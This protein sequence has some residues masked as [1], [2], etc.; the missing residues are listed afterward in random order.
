M[1]LAGSYGGAALAEDGRM[2]ILGGNNGGLPLDR[3]E[4][5]QVM[6]EE[7]TLS[8]T[9]A[10]PDAQI[11]VTVALDFAYVSPSSYDLEVYFESSTGTVF[12]VGDVVTTN[13]GTFAFGVDVPSSMPLGDYT[14]VLSDL[15]FRS[16]GLDWN[17]GSRDFAFSVVD[18][19]TLDEQIAALEANVIAL[20]MAMIQAMADANA[21]TMAYLQAQLTALQGVLAQIGGGLTTMGAGQVA[22]MAALNATLADL[23]LQLDAF[24]E[25]I[26]RVEDKADTAGMY[27]LITMVLVLVIVVLVA[28]VLMMSRKSKVPPP[29]AP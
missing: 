25:Q 24:Q 29:P 11:L 23:Q 17:L 13:A 18:V 14:L 8:A 6:T 10:G 4:T 5:L 12:P 16:P 27:G 7:I 22:A 9:S 26:N 2:L 21:S 20:Q 19:L 15:Y 28:L 1:T 3:V